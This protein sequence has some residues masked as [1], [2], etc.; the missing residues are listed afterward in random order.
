M[1]ETAAPEPQQRISPDHS[2]QGERRPVES[3]VEQGSPE[4]PNMLAGS[5]VDIQSI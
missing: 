1:A 2:Q 3:V 4:H 5:I